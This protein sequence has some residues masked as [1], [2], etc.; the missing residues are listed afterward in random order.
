MAPTK[1]KEPSVDPQERDVFL[2]ALEKYHAQRGTIL[3]REARVGSRQIDLFKLWK[4]VNAE[5]GYDKVS[6]IKNNKLAWRR[7]ASEYLPHG[8]SLTN[9]A[10]LVK[11]IYYRNLACV[12]YHRSAAHC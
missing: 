10:F 5:G 3:D 9:Q 8:P 12:P 1:P 4:R 2:D 11:S 7:I 6:D